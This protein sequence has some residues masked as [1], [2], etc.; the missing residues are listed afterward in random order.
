MAMTCQAMYDRPSN[1]VGHSNAYGVNNYY[2][3]SLSVRKQPYTKW[4]GLDSTHVNKH[5][6]G[7]PFFE[8]TPMDEA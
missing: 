7:R 3:D 2:G 8:I 5:V 1:G 4:D 6:N